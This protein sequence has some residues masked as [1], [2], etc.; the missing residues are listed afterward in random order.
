[1]RDRTSRLQVTI[2]QKGRQ[3]GPLN[4]VGLLAFPPT[5]ATGP[6]AGQKRPPAAM[7]AGVVDTL[8]SFDRFFDEVMQYEGVPA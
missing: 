3:K 4:S 5:E 1:M 7:M 6:V 8:W 2:R